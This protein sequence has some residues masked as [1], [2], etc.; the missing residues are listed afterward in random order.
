MTFDGLTLAAM[1]GELQRKL[2]GARVQKAVQPDAVGIA[3]ELYG[4]RS[5]AWLVLSAEP[6]QPRLYLASEKPGRGVETP[7]PLLLLLRKHVEGLR[8]GEIAQ[9][10]GERIVRFGFF[11]H[12]PDG[13]GEPATLRF[14]LIIEAISQ[15]SNLI[16]VDAAGQVLDAAR[17]VTA[18][19]NRARVTLPHQPYVPPPTQNKRSLAEADDSAVLAVLQAAAL[20][21]TIWQTLVAGFAGIGPLGGREIVYRA[22]G[23]ARACLPDG[24]VEP[25]AERVAAALH[26]IVQP[27]LDGS[28]EA[29]VAFG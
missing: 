28:F 1:A 6:Q 27:V 25:I 9:P 13:S 24:N 26:Q 3:L 18:E 11:G 23:D 21:A 20:G 5:R 19:Q 8:L 15:Y 14:R 10:P 7:S 4:Q 2:V 12:A 16:L 22:L 29:S 17:R